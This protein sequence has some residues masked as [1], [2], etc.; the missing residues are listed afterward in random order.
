M[1]IEAGLVDPLNQFTRNDVESGSF[2]TEHVINFDKQ[3]S[4]EFIEKIKK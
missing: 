2:I 4:Q 3:K 1:C